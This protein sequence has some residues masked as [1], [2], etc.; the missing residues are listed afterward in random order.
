MPPIRVVEKDGITN[1]EEVKG[2][3]NTSSGLVKGPSSKKLDP[4]GRQDS[5]SW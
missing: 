1:G 2:G 4:K 5:Q 3:S